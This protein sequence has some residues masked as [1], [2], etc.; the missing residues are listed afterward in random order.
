MSFA[1]HAVGAM[2]FMSLFKSRR[3]RPMSA[4]L[5]LNNRLVSVWPWDGVRDCTT[6]VDVRAVD[7]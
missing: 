6:I 2:S 3:H 1:G 4:C 7:F 5:A